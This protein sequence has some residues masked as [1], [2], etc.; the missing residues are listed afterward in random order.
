MERRHLV[1]SAGAQLGFN[2]L[3]IYSTDPTWLVTM[4]SQSGQILG[5]IPGRVDIFDYNKK[6]VGWRRIRTS[7]VFRPSGLKPDAFD[8][9]AIQSLMNQ[10][11]LLCYI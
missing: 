1:R 6:T 3:W 11:D 10:L 4:L 7:E 2:P 8:R 9:S 5:S